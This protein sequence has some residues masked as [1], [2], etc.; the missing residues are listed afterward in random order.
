MNIADVL[1]YNRYHAEK[2]VKGPKRKLE[3]KCINC[4]KE[5]TCIY[6]RGVVTWVNCPDFIQKE[7]RSGEN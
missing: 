5:D 3:N 6:G 4:R 1:K 7:T 2:N